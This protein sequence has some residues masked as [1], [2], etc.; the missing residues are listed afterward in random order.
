MHAVRASSFSISIG[1][2]KYKKSK[3]IVVPRDSR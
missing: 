3:N 1:I 2:I